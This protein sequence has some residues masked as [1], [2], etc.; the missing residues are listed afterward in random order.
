[1]ASVT[2]VAERFVD[3]YALV[4]PVR[5]ARSMGVAVDAT[6]LTDFSPD[7]L[8]TIGEFLRRTR[9][10]LEAA[11]AESEAER[12]GRL[13]LLGSIDGDLAMLD[14]GERQRLVSILIGPPSMVRMTFDLMSR[15]SDE[16][17]ERVAARLEAVPTAMAGYRASLEDAAA[18][19]EAASAR[20]VAAAAEQC[21]TWGGA[22]GG[23]F[24]DFVS[25]SG[26][27]AGPLR[28]RLDAAA[29]SAGDAYA[30]LGRWMA[31]ELAPKADENDGVGDDRYRTWARSMLGASLDLDDTYD[32]GWEELARIER[33]KAAECERILPGAGFEEVRDLLSSD[34][35]RA[36]HGVDAYRAWLQ[37]ITDDA[38]DR[39]DGTQFDIPDP[40]RRCE[41][42]IPPE[43]SAAAPYYTPPSEDLS[44]PGRTWFPTL[45][46]ERFPTWDQVTI[47]YHE[48]VPGHH[49]QLGMT[50]VVPLVRAHRVGFNAAHGEGGALYAERLM[51]ELGFFDD[52]ATRL[53]FLS[54]QA[55]RAVRVVIDIGLHTG[56]V[57]PA[58][59]HGAG[60]RW[61]AELAAAHLERAGGLSPAFAES[62]VVRYVGMP[63]QAISYKVGERAWLQGRAAASLRD[64]FDLKAWHAR[65]LAL[66]ALGLD[67]L[68]AELPGC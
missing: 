51:D 42:G 9:S 45:G 37:E 68:A 43:G 54:S 8:A 17:W 48:A 56:R 30:E 67:D 12:L 50:R 16:D 24:A 6:T 40:L 32:W 62:E 4:E 22:D 57:I 20:S 36:V 35:E 3:E 39:L 47:A 64:G 1:M 53:G 46:E 21:R 14:S 25:G 38:I 59:W 10:A 52:P 13:Y 58:G 19:G 27:V 26:D 49:L 31:E 11:T 18:R 66:G 5:A 65:A 33:E 41:I 15:T 2:E 7:G 23:W 63:S 28:S 44:R 34:P 55:F 61:N 29:R 60:Q